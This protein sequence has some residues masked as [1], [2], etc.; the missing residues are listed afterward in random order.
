ML[1]EKGQKVIIKN[2]GVL[3]GTVIEARPSDAGEPEDRRHYEVRISDERYYL[4]GDLEPFPPA[5]LERF[6][7][8]WYAEMKRWAEAAVRWSQNHDDH[9]AWDQF[10]ES[11]SKLGIFVPTKK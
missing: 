1:F 6:S 3:V 9:A 10:A 2:P 4:S 7:N 5:K 11:G 8:E